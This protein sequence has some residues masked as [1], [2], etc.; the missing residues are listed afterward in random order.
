[1]ARL[2]RILIIAGSDSSGGAG[3]QADIKTVSALGGYA[4]T[5]ITA[6]TAQ[7]TT[8]VQAVH[9]IPPEHIAAQ[10]RSCI[11]DIGVD[12]IKIGMLHSKAVIETVA[13]KLPKDV[14]LVLDPVMVATS[15]ARLMEQEA[16]EALKTLLI[17]RATLLTPNLPEAE[18]LGGTDQ[19]ALM[20]LGAQAVLLKGGHSDAPIITDTLYG[21]GEPFTLR[22]E[23]I[24]SENTHGTGCTLASAMATFIGQGMELREAMQEAVSYVCQAIEDAPTLGQGHGPLGWP[25]MKG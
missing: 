11:S 24:A 20:A 22:H 14:P 6:T 18:V 17:P 23:R 16:I 19:K 12:A 10:M 13:A 15:G 3:I 25:S 4:M 8:G 2:A 9:P 5:A 7:N 1:M 21:A